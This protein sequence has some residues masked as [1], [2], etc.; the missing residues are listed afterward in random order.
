MYPGRKKTI[1]SGRKTIV[2]GLRTSLWVSIFSNAGV[3]I[4]GD[5]LIKSPQLLS[6][7]IILIGPAG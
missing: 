7:E 1:V 6:I 3:C 4:T 2:S 5:L